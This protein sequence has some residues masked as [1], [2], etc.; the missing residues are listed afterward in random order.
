MK[1]KRRVTRFAVLLATVAAVPLTASCQVASVAPKP[2]ATTP[3]RSTAP[4]VTTQG[5]GAAVTP[6]PTTAGHTATTEPP[7]PGPWHLAFTDKGFAG[8]AWVTCYD[9]NNNGCTNSTNDDK[10]WYQPQQV[11][12]ANGVATLTAKRQSV[13]GSTGKRYTW[14][15]GMISTGRSSW[16]ARPR[17][18]FTYGYVQAEIELP[19]TYGTM[20]AFW[21]MPT[22]EHT[23]PEVDIVEM[24]ADK[25]YPAITLHWPGPNHADLFSQARYGPQTFT[26]SYHTFGVDWER[27]AITWYIDGVP[28]YTVTAPTH[29]PH[30]PMEILVTLEVGYPHV[31]RADVNTSQVHV[32]DV[33]VWQH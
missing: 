26:G 14:V 5:G 9:W 10:Q 17:Y 29:I 8:S 28:R 22:T 30:G 3:G 24:L 18:T 4:T 12:I 23:P 11:S 6:G 1:A 19:S 7:A 16:N 31:P 2:A 33:R 27:D 25:S 13:L 20:P 21:L 32:R 15:S